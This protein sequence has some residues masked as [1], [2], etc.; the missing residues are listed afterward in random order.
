MDEMT[1][2]NDI[3]TIVEAVRNFVRSCLTGQEEFSIFQHEAQDE[4]ASRSEP[5]RKGHRV[6]S[7]RRNRGDIAR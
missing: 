3:E 4:K 5:A 6:P 2:T 7:N 1:D